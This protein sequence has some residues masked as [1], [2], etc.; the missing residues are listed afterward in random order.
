MWHEERLLNVCVLQGEHFSIL[1]I[2]WE[3]LVSTAFLKMHISVFSYVLQ[4][5]LFNAIVVFVENA[6]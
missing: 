1:L 2:C 4:L 3:E 5:F 6:V